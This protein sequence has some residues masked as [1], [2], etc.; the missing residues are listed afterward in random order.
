MT[1]PTHIVILAATVAA[2]LATGCASTERARDAGASA[3]D[4]AAIG[5]SP[6]SAVVPPSTPLPAALKGY[7]LYGWDEA[8]ELHFTLI[9]G[10]NR[11]KT[12]AEITAPAAEVITAD[13]VAIGAAGA[14]QLERVLARVPKGTPV[15]LSDLAGLPSLSSASR[16]MLE[17]ALAATQ[18]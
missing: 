1:L 13:W 14:S 15:V 3:R 6:D 17:Q 5:T 10:T 9:T 8:G 7:E 11:Q 18:S 12:T 4:A 16:T 2:T